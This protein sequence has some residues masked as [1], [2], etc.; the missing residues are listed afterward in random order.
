MV[1]LRKL[2][3]PAGAEQAAG[4]TA[5]ERRAHVRTFAVLK[6]HEA[7]HAH[8]GEYMKNQNQGF[9]YFIPSFQP[10]AAWQMARNSSA[11]S[12]APPIK[13]PSTSRMPNNSAA[14]AALTLPP[15][16]IGI[17]AAILLSRSARTPRK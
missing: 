8:R 4:G 10:S 12:E 17:D 3:D 14:L 15:Y 13:P 16:R 11:T 7:D 9:H 5:A 6:Q 2:A 1:R